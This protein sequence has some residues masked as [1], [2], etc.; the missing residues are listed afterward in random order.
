[1]FPTKAE[2]GVAMAITRRAAFRT[3]IIMQWANVSV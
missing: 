2:T 3:S 1:V